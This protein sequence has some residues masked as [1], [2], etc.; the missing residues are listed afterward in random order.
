MKEWIASEGWVLGVLWFDTVRLV[1]RPG[2]P[3]T[4]GLGQAQGTVIGPFAARGSWVFWLPLGILPLGT[5]K[6]HP[7]RIRRTSGRPGGLAANGDRLGF[8][9]CAEDGRDL[10][11]GPAEGVR[12]EHLCWDVKG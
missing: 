10:D 1:H 3:R 11:A 12:A 4:G 6:G 7:Y 5:H 2:S 8:D 9:G